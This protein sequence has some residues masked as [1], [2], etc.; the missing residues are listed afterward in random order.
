MMPEKKGQFINPFTDFGFKRLF[1]TEKNKDILIDFLNELLSKKTGPI[2]F[3]KFLNSEKIGISDDDRRS[4]FD[5]YCENELGEKFIIEM[6]KAKQGFFRDRM[7]YYAT[8][9]IQ[10]QAPKG[11]WNYE[12]K[13]VYAIALMDFDFTPKPKKGDVIEQPTEYVHHVQLMNTKTH[14]IFSDKLTFVYAEMPKFTLKL[15]E[16]KTRYEKW[17]YIL[18]HLSDMVSIPK[19]LNKKGAFKQIFS[20][21]KYSALSTKERTAYEKDLKTYR[22]LTNSFDTAR[23]E[24]IAEG[25]EQGIEQGIERGIERERRMQGERRTHEKIETAKEMLS[26]GVPIKTIAKYTKLSVK[27]IQK[28]SKK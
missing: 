11:S 24:G 19:E 4:I 21:A 8:F 12:L 13:A 5:I 22:D 3:I 15:S 1:G 14:E 9:P 17:F 25:I 23:D 26:D 27:E 28:L 2:K 7:L 10:D 16:C 20:E 18:N 6:Q